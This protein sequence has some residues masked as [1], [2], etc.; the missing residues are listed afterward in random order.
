[1]SDRAAQRLTRILSMLPWVMANQD[2][3]TVDEVC[4]RFGYEPRELARD[5]DL[6]MVCGLPGYLPHDLMYASV[7]GDEV[8]V[9]SADY[10]AGPR[11]LTA[12]EGLRLLAAALATDAAGAG[13]PALRSAADKL[14]RVLLPGEGTV[15]VEVAEDAGLVPVLR[16]AVARGR[17]LRLT[18]WGA[19]RDEVT[20]REVD[21]WQV[22]TDLGRW[23]LDGLDHRSGEHR[24]FR[25]DRI[26]EASETGE[27]AT[28]PDELPE[29]EVTYVPGADDVRAIIGLAPQARWV[30]EYYPVTVL[31]EDG[32]RLRVEFSASGT[33]VP[34]R[35]LLRLGP[36]ASLEAGDEVAAA[37][38]DLREAML[39]RYRSP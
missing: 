16:E 29:P 4:A 27:P 35:L 22:F 15:A 39:D 37:L 24:R 2:L 19:A 28:R 9:E 21:P 13:S 36:Q 38:A 8:V 10:F 20:E 32:D 5:L 17:R 12:A 31:G 30:A 7:V 3:A 14:A 6:V 25:V 26:V 23:Y 11:R 1:M 34:A 33:A 18:Y